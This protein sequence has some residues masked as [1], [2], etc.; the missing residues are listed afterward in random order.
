MFEEVFSN[1][2]G[3]LKK[4]L[5]LSIY[6]YYIMRYKAT[7]IDP[8]WKIKVR[9]DTGPWNV[10]KLRSVMYFYRLT[11]AEKSASMC[12]AA[13]KFRLHQNYI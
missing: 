5:L 4:W 13:I 7:S 2:F 8:R 6:H 1:S 9:L 3:N 11:K 12:V 10:S